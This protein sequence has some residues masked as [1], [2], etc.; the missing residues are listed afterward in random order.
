MFE[1]EICYFAKYVYYRKIC[2]VFGIAISYG[3]ACIFQ[4]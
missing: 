4:R 3:D 2:H 1:N